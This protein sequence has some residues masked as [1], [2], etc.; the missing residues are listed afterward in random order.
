[1]QD[2]FIHVSKI[3]RNKIC[4]RDVITSCF[5]NFFIFTMLQS[6]NAIKISNVDTL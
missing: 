3:Y 2:R 5:S 1:M 6:K 4:L